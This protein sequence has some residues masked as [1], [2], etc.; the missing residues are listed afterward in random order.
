MCG[1]VAN[2]RKGKWL[3]R[4][5]PRADSVPSTRGL[6]QHGTSLSRKGHQDD[7]RNVCEQAKQTRQ[8]AAVSSVAGR[9]ARCF[10]RLPDALELFEAFRTVEPD[11]LADMSSFQ[12]YGSVVWKLIFERCCGHDDVEVDCESCGGDVLAALCLIGY[13]AGR[14]GLCATGDEPELCP[15]TGLLNPPLAY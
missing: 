1:A 4:K 10:W 13:F 14:V 15:S 9:S 2:I 11:G 7:Q 8:R 6:I 5:C 3:K 12:V